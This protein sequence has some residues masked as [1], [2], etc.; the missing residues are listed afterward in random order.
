MAVNA[1]G[2]PARWWK[3]GSGSAQRCAP[4]SL[5]VSPMRRFATIVALVFFLLVFGGLW[6]VTNPARVS[7]LSEVLLSRVLGGHVS[8]RTGQLSWS[9]TLLLSGVDVRTTDPEPVPG[10]EIPIFSAEQLEV[11]FDWLSLLS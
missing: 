3:K 8:V 4:G 5:F 10:S 7:R 9:G 2:N 1:R 6:Y 11:R